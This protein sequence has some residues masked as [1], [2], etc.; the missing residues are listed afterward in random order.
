MDTDKKKYIGNWECGK[1]GSKITELPFEPDPSRKGSLKCGECHKKS[2]SE[3][4]DF[5]M[6]EGDWKCSGC[7]NAITQLPFDP[8]ENT[9]G[10][11]C[12]DCYKRKNLS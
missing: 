3:K 11:L 10:L 1:C 9:E 4:K 8:S 5:K 12:R 6:H 2:L 7:G